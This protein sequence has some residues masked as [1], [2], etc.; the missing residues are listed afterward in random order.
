MDT[1]RQL[2]GAEFVNSHSAGHLNEFVY[3][4]AEIEM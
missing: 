3:I 1:G 4:E 2:Q